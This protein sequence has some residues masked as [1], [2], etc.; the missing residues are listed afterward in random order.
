M[1]DYQLIIF[2]LSLNERINEI[3][4]E[5]EEM[6]C[7][8]VFPNNE[9]IA[10]GETYKVAI[11]NITNKS[12]VHTFRSHKGKVVKLAVSVDNKR[13]FSS[14]KDGMVKIYDTT[15]WQEISMIEESTSLSIL[16]VSRD[17]EY[18]FTS[19]GSSNLKIWGIKRMTLL[20]TLSNFD[21][22]KV[23]FNRKL[24]HFAYFTSGNVYFG[25]LN[26]F[27]VI[28][29][30][31]VG[32]N[33]VDMALS[34]DETE[35]YV[36]KGDETAVLP[37]P[38]KSRK[39]EIHGEFENL[40]DYIK[41]VNSLSSPNVLHK[42][43]YDL[44]IIEPF[45]INTLHLYAY[46]NQTS[47]LHESIIN[48]SPFFPSRTGHTPLSIAVEKKFLDSI[49]SIYKALKTRLDQL[50]PWAFYHIGNSIEGLNDLGFNKLHKIYELCLVKSKDKTLP[51]FCK[52]D[53][54]LPIIVLSDC[55]ILDPNDFLYCENLSSE[56]NALA[57]AQTGFRLY[58]ECGS[59]K[60]LEFLESVLNC[61]NESIYY[62]K[63]IQIILDYKWKKLRWFIGLQALLYAIYLLLLAVYSVL[64]KDDDWLLICTFILSTVLFSYE[65]LQL[66]NSGWGYF[67]DFWNYIDI[68]RGILFYTYLIMVLS[69]LQHT[70]SDPVFTLVV[71]L[72][73]A[74]G[75]TY[76]K[77]AESTRY[78]INLIVEA[79]IDILSFFLLLF[80]STVAFALLMQ[81][82]TVGSTSESFLSFF[83]ESYK[84]NLGELSEDPESVFRWV[85]FMIICIVNPVIMLNLLISIMA[86]TYGRVKLGKVAAD[87]RELT[88]LIIEVESLMSWKREKNSSIFLKI[89]CKESDLVIEDNSIEAKIDSLSDSIKTLEENII[90]S[91]TTIFEALK[92][93]EQEITTA[94]R[95]KMNNLE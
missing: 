95:N 54:D 75:I 49:E 24:D 42:I 72:S 91:K 61:P 45:H 62:T 50:D 39:L 81:T 58:L 43:E 92:A 2:S 86:D 46:Y 1:T 32:E 66:Y 3:K 77:L 59:Q 65:G 16:Q 20:C 15:I 94:I 64:E 8:I 41:Y 26:N 30:I 28:C 29:C 22:T 60:S 17:N 4:I 56:G 84:Q 67:E 35:I 14:G 68:A 9:M 53:T 57:F 82:F 52:E 48:H 38:F 40:Y 44:W 83:L 71:F 37:N 89:A 78:L 76:F 13:L 63:I 87:A 36:T 88:G 27:E 23:I 25:D 90:K 69:G 31:R 5:Q 19:T 10:T 34:D 47:L 12:L 33:I 73:W 79:S 11:W 18:L 85:L 93:T 7:G 55:P 6:F 21:S 74:R 70:S 51:K 80:Y